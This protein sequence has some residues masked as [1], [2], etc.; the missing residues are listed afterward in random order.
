[1]LVVGIGTSVAPETCFPILELPH[2]SGLVHDT[3]GCESHRVA[4]PLQFRP[5]EELLLQIN[6]GVALDLQ[7][8]VDAGVD[9][10][11]PP[12]ACFSDGVHEEDHALSEDSLALHSDPMGSHTCF[13][14]VH[15]PVCTTTLIRRHGHF[16]LPLV[17]STAALQG[18]GG[19]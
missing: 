10:L 14:A 4:T 17:T 12:V 16:C 6:P 19:W 18:G 9:V 1:L 13:I 8:L 5:M 2:M 7:D 3:R 11:D 15:F